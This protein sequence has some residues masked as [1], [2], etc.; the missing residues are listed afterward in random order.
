MVNQVSSTED[1]TTG[2]GA[3]CDRHKCSFV[4]IDGLLTAQG[5]YT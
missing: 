4:I 3:S 1:E 2:L 5:V